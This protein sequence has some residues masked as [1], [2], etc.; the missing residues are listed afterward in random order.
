MVVSAFIKLLLQFLY[1]LLLGSQFVVQLDVLGLFFRQLLLK[2]DNL[3][4]HMLPLLVAHR[5][6]LYLFQLLGELEGLL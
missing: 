1:L 3:L 4:L 5:L 2:H 6:L